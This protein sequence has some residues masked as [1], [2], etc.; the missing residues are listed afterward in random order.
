MSKLP[1]PHAI[2]YHWCMIDSTGEILRRLNELTQVVLALRGSKVGPT[3][4]TPHGLLADDLL[5]GADAIASF[6]YGDPKKRNKV[7]HLA[8]INGIPTFNLGALVCARKSTLL[9]WIKS[10]EAV[11]G[12]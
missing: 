4:S 3:A 10:Q 9:E 11:T 1:H 8:R 7:Y 6:L 2:H 12:T 5:Q